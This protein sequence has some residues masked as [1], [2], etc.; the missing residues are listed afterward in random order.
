[1]PTLVFITLIA[2]LFLQLMASGGRW[3]CL[4]VLGL[5]IYVFPVHFLA[6]ALI[7]AGGLYY[8]DTYRKN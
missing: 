7:A 6:I 4:V 8:F 2:V 3:A 1:M 5:L